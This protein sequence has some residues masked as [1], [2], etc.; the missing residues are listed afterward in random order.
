MSVTRTETAQ[1]STNAPNPASDKTIIVGAL[2][3]PNTGLAIFLALIFG[4]LGLFYSS[5]LGGVLMLII[6]IPVTI[7]TF[8]LGLFL[9]L[10]L[11]AIWAGIAS[12]AKNRKAQAQ[13]QAATA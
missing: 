9:I 13:L 11:C 4:P 1:P 3:A 7:V 2:N 6:A 5:V 8:G 10:P 12:G